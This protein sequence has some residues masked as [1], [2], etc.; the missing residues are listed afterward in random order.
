[1][2]A[3]QV[4]LKWHQALTAGIYSWT[5]QSLRIVLNSQINVDNN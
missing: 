4:P 2:S 5:L 3:I 1:M